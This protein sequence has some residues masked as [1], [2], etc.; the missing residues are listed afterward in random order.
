MEK[1]NNSSPDADLVSYNQVQGKIV[2]KISKL[3]AIISEFVT[4]IG[5]FVIL[6]II[7]ISYICSSRK[8]EKRIAREDARRLYNKPKYENNN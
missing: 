5:M 3:G 4:G 1:Y 2:F 6:A 7:I 8:E